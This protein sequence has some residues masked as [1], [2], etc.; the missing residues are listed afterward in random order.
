MPRPWRE[1]DA[2]WCVLEDIIKR[3]SILAHHLTLGTERQN[4]LCQIPCEGIDVVDEEDAHA[5]SISYL[6]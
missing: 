1:H 2:I 3:T 4:E 6:V 5:R